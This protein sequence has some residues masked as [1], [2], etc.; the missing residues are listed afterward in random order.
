MT[1]TD[2]TTSSSEA[3]IRLTGNE[4]TTIE[5]V[6]VANLENTRSD[7][8]EFVFLSTENTKVELN[9]VSSNILIPSLSKYPTYF[10]QAT[11]G[12]EIAINAISLSGS[13]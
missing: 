13:I 6:E 2:F 10:M 12:C 5:N 11:Y 3:F 8:S 1:I 4:D 9:T 7:L